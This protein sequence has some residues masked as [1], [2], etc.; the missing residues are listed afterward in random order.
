MNFV[1]IIK[2]IAEITHFFSEIIEKIFINKSI[3][4]LL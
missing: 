1:K 3:V 4:F 2:K